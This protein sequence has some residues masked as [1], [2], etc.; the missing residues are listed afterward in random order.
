M[1]DLGTDFWNAI[2]AATNSGG[3][4]RVQDSTLTEIPREVVSVDDVAETGELWVKVPFL[5]SSVATDVHIYV[6]SGASEPP[7][8]SANGRNS[9][10]SDYAVV[11]HLEADGTDSSGNAA[12][13]Q[14]GTVNT[15]TGQVGGA[16]RGLDSS[17]HYLYDSTGFSQTATLQAWVRFDSAPSN[18]AI[19]VSL[20]DKDSTNQQITLGA[21][22]GDGFPAIGLWDS[23]GLIDYNAAGSFSASTWQMIHGVKQA[24][25]DSLLYFNGAFLSSKA[26]D[27]TPTNVDRIAIGTSADK[28]PT[29][30]AIQVDEARVRFGVLSPE[31]IATEYANQSSTATFYSVAANDPN[32]GSGITGLLSVSESG[33]DTAAITGTVSFAEITGTLSATESGDD[34]ASIAGTVSFA[35]IT[36][37][38]TVSESGQDTFSASGAL[39]PQTGGVMVAVEAGSDAFAGAG[40]DRHRQDARHAVSDAE[41]LA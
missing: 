12:A 1:A 26:N 3:A 20:A 31:W 4:I 9:V 34:A 14:N 28:T 17:G 25:M 39:V 7:E 13:V 6:D 5:S 8:A 27:R 30:G 19:A 40:S 35:E 21:T 16:I 2:R 41:R 24:G 38:L 11:A 36:G 29:G 18:T 10:W 15:Q 32:A 22:F 37:T 33:D 23:S